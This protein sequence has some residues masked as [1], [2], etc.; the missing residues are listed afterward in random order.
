M[1]GTLVAT[2]NKRVQLSAYRDKPT[3]LFFEGRHATAVNQALKDELL[4]WAKAH[5]ALASVN[6]VAV[7]NLTPFDFFPARQFAL[8]AVRDIEKKIGIPIL[9]D[10]AGSL[11]RPP[12][13]LPPEESTVLLLARD[14]SVLW[15]RSGTVSAA[16]TQALFTLLDSFVT[17]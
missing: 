17:R 11:S 14:G 13:D 12:N 16:D 2:N 7:A 4:P 6:L 15:R 3:L 1:D 9:V 5:G 8:G 10:F